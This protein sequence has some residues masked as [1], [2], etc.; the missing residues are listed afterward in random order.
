MRAGIS[1][2]LMRTHAVRMAGVEKRRVA[3]VDISIL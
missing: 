1:L 2:G 3:G